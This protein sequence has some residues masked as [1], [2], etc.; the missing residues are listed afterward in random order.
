MNPTELLI[1][2]EKTAR[3]ASVKSCLR[4]IPSSHLQLCVVGC[5]VVT[6]T[7]FALDR[8]YLTPLSSLTNRHRLLNICSFFIL[9]RKVVGNSQ[10]LFDGEQIIA[11]D[12]N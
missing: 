12:T 1:F 7:R 6:L 3:G 2:P 8:D 11:S 9:L 10:K 5:S 4:L